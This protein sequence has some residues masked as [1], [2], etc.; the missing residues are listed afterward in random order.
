MHWE[1]DRLEEVLQVASSDTKN[2]AGH[3]LGIIKREEER[4]VARA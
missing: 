1:L 4:G 2:W 3:W